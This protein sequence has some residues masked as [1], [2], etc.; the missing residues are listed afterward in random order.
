M[1]Y[2]RWP[3]SRSQE[4]SSPTSY[5]LSPNSG[6]RRSH[7]PREA[8]GVAHIN[9]TTGELRLDNRNLAV[10][11]VAT[12]TDAL[13]SASATP[14]DGVRLAKGSQ[15]PHLGL[16]GASIWRISAEILRRVGDLADL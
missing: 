10:I 16:T 15:R 2:S 8:F 1:S 7:Q 13:R 11:R 14:S 9:I 3:K 5:D 4:T 12:A 6:R